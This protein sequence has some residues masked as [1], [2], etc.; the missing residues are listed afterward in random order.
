MTVR[1]AHDSTVRP[2]SLEL[3]PFSVGD[4]CASSSTWKGKEAEESKGEDSAEAGRENEEDD[5]MECEVCGPNFGEEGEE[6]RRPKLRKAADMPTKREVLEHNL[7][8]VPY[9]SWCPHCVRGRGRSE[10]RRAGA[11]KGKE[12]E[13]PYLTL[14]YGYLHEQAKE[15]EAV[16]RD[17]APVL[18]GTDAQ[19]GLGMAMLV[20]G[21]GASA[22]WVAKRLARW[23]DRLGSSRVVVKTD[24]ENAIVDLVNEVRKQRQPG[25]ATIPESPE[26]G[27]SQSNQYAESAVNVN[28]GLIRTL[29]DATEHNLGAKIDRAH[30]LLPWIIEHAPQLRNKYQVSADGRTPVERLRGRSVARP[31]FEIGERV[32]YVP[33]KVD[34]PKKGTMGTGIYLGSVRLGGCAVVGTPNGVVRCRAIKPMPEEK[35]VEAE[36][37]EEEEEE[38]AAVR[39]RKAPVLP[40]LEVQRRHNR[41]HIPFRSWCRHCVEARQPH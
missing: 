25:S 13:C 17:T 21:K 24:N 10:G 8:H 33:L 37:E 38:D 39:G 32:H 26:E 41:T 14:D 40:P 15:G 23:I 30:P 12:F 20:P 35:R 29:I 27:E 34:V 31:E 19:T 6:W 16:N 3:M 4:G 2:E 5:T 9:R 28:K 7:T 1:N 11:V 22:P 36:E 18:F